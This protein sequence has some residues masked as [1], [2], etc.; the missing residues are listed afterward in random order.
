MKM[1]FNEKFVN[2]WLLTLPRWEGIALGCL[3]VITLAFL[4]LFPL[5]QGKRFRKLDLAT[6]KEGS[7]PLLFLSSLP[8]WISLF[9][10]IVVSFR[11]YHGIGPEHVFGLRNLLHPDEWPSCLHCGMDF[12]SIVDYSL[13]LG[14]ACRIPQEL[15]VCLDAFAKYWYIPMAASVLALLFRSIFFKSVGN[16]LKYLLAMLVATNAVYWV[17]GTYL[18]FIVMPVMIF[19][20]AI[21]A[22]SFWGLFSLFKGGGSKR[23][24]SNDDAGGPPSDDAGGTP[25]DDTAVIDDGSWNGR[26]IKEHWDG[27]YDSDGNRFEKNIDGSFSLKPKD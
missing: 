10:A 25:S 6:C 18:T 23:E 12:S 17:Y 9:S 2:D 14:I 26:E 22:W 16:A 13:P 7:E 20:V 11:A 15:A 21:V 24:D 4:A 27:W 19:I 1:F 8:Y 3:F 5:F